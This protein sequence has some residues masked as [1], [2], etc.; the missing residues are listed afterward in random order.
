MK[1]KTLLTTVLAA[2][3]GGFV[4][5]VSYFY[6]FEPDRQILEE[7]LTNKLAAGNNNFHYVSFG[8]TGLPD[9]TEAAE[10]SVHAVVHIKTK[11]T[12]EYYSN[13][14]YDFFFGVPSRR[15][16]QVVP[17]SSGSGVIVSPNGYIVTNF[18]VIRNADI[19]E[20]TLNDKRKYKAQVVG[21]DKMTDL[22]LLKI[23]AKDLPFLEYGDS[24]KLKVGEWVLAV[25]N[26]FNLTSTVTAGIVSAKA[27]SLSVMS[28]YGIEAY[29]QTDAAVNPGNS[30]GALVNTKGQLVGINAAIAS[31][32][33]SYTG[34][35]FAI[36][37]NIVKKVVAD[38][39][40]YGKVQ[41][42]FIGASIVDLNADIAKY[43][44]IKETEGVYIY[45]LNPR[46]AAYEA[47]MQKGDIITKINN[48]DIK[49][50][51]QLQEQLAKYRPGDIVTFTVLRDGKT[52]TFE[53]KLKNVY[54]EDKI[55]Y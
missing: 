30:G 16:E 51:P 1:N 7:I 21:V 49:S 26:P 4:S 34:Y 38:L 5:V 23:D 15:Y 27:R 35:S 32:T 39:I 55:R 19:I 11:F 31:N 24:D 36:P 54:G 52:L 2:V 47:G 12:E 22:A 43:L 44:G 14:I 33:G 50:L 42:A 3:I 17:L 46:G 41:R 6:F 37:V 13:P 45:D 48:T 20:V 28:R 18:H 8:E 10:K 53:V 40:K 9:F 29:I 25:G